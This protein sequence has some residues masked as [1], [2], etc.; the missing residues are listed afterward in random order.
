ML[1]IT[2]TTVVTAMIGNITMSHS[3]FKWQGIMYCSLKNTKLIKGTIYLKL[4]SILK[5]WFHIL[6]YIVV[7]F[8]ALC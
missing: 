4:V 6:G 8:L 3:G 2:V 1:K 7:R 5:E